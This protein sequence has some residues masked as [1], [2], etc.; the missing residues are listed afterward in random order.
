MRMESGGQRR[1]TKGFETEITAREIKKIDH[2]V[3]Q[4]EVLEHNKTQ[5]YVYMPQ[6]DP[7]FFND[8]VQRTVDTL[9]NYKVCPVC[10]KQFYIPS[11][12]SVKAW[13]YKVKDKPACSWTCSRRGNQ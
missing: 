1:K 10:G 9:G 7:T 3:S 8:H 13:V 11:D 4:I 12:S 2:T 6:E 5:G